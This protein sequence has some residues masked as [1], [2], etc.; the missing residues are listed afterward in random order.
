MPQQIYDENRVNV[1]ENHHHDS[2]KNQN[3]LFLSNQL[4]KQNDS[5][6]NG[7]RKKNHERH[8]E[9]LSLLIAK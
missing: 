9:Q 6:N 1:K 5:P 4:E 7:N 8:K 2:S 3:F